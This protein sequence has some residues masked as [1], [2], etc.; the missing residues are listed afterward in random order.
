ME[1]KISIMKFNILA[2][3]CIIIFAF[4]VSPVSLQNDT[5][6]TIAIGEYIMQNGVTDVEP[7]AWHE[8]LKYTYPHWAYDVFIYLVYNLGGQ[9]GI[10]LSTVLLA[11]LLGISMYF[12]SSKYSRN[13]LIAFLMTLLAMYLIRAFI[14]ARAQ[15]VTFILFALTIYFIEKFLE[16]KKKRYAA[17]LI[18]IPIIISNVHSAVFP[19]Y[20]VLY[21][22]YI[23][24]YIISLLSDIDVL[25]Y[26]LKI[27]KQENII[28][29]E[30]DLKDEELLKVL[31]DDLEDYKAKL[32]K[33]E[34]RKKNVTSYKVIL[35]R[36]DN[37]KWLIVIAI[38]CAFTGLLT[39]IGDMPYTY[40]IRITEGNTTQ[41]INEHLPLTIAKDSEF[42]TF[43]IITLLIYIFTPVKMRLREWFMLGGLIFLAFMTRRQESMVY[44][45]GMIIVT[46]AICDLIDKYDEKGTEEVMT[47]IN[48]VCGKII[49]VAVVLIITL[50]LVKPKMSD[51]FIRESSY[52]IKASDY[53]VENI[54]LES[55]KI[56]NDY[57]YGSYLLYRGIP[58]FIDSRSDL[59]TPQFNEGKDIFTDFL[60][61]SNLNGEYETIFSKYEITHV[62]QFKNSKLSGM[63]RKDSNYNTIYEDDHFVLF[64]RLT[65]N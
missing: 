46:K 9:V 53:I 30:K 64:E 1:N 25:F 54:D 47:F 37:V 60:N 21:M 12:V 63:L 31:N 36:N 20:F 6:Y 11:A 28:E 65:S 49:T 27:K 19:F 45:I 2:V 5:F 13:R 40:L 24:E 15:L 50:V 33:R 55:M 35:E 18:I 39:P 52:P 43:F 61:I 7:F 34:E 56:Y 38:I 22:P 14:A 48:T 32:A 42:A 57:N 51:D 3:L 8:G 26:R 17:G 58:V 23:G 62:I 44:L 41:N 10:Y 16:T 4:A 29:K 59:Y